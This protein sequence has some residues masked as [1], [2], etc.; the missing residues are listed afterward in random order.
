MIVAL[1]DHVIT[2]PAGYTAAFLTVACAGLLARIVLL[3]RA[4]ARRPVVV[5]AVARVSRPLPPAPGPDR[6]LVN[7]RFAAHIAARSAEFAAATRAG[8][9]VVGPPWPV[10]DPAHVVAA[11][12]GGGPS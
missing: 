11:R 1:V 5:R 9:H 2:H 6:P 10:V 4:D 3:L 8:R 12:H 7:P